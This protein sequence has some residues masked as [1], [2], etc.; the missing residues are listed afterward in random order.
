MLTIP[1]FWDNPSYVNAEIEFLE[2]LVKLCRTARDPKRP[3]S[4]TEIAVPAAQWEIR[5][6]DRIK[7]LKDQNPQKELEVAA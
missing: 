1:K 6:Q 5:F 2:M 4:R 7:Q 3:K